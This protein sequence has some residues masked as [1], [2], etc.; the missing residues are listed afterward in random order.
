MKL[1]PGDRICAMEIVAPNGQLLVVTAAGHA[2]RTPL[3]QFPIHNRGVGG[4]MAL[5]LTDKS[6]PIATARVV[7]G[8]E[9]AMV[10]STSGIVLRT[11]VA[12]ISVQ[13]RAAGG[14][15]LMSLKAGDRVACVA[16]LNANG[17][18]EAEQGSDE[19]GRRSSGQ[20][21]ASEPADQP[22]LDLVDTDEDSEEE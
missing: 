18:A 15:A 19:P 16:L 4:V 9:E 3:A 1:A 12:S 7:N 8:A 17:P 22:E 20:T 2:K 6:G 10:T 21:E 11:P 14:V 13:G 5:K